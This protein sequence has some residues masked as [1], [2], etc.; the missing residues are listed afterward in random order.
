M[1]ERDQ[2][3]VG[4]VLSMAGVQ[5]TDVAAHHL[6]TM[7]ASVGIRIG[8]ALIYV[9]ERETAELFGR[10][11]D[12]QSRAAAMLPHRLGPRGAREVRGAVDAAVMM[13]VHGLPPVSGRL[14]RPP[15]RPTHLRVQLARVV[16]DIRDQAAFVS[17]RA[18][19]GDACVLG[20][21]VLPAGSDARLRQQRAFGQ[22][23][24]AVPRAARRQGSGT[25]RRA[26]SPTPP[27]AAPRRGPILGQEHTG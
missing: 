11:W 27:P 19:F 5:D 14:V 6:S 23:A 13:N 18:A 24:A 1:Y 21:S 22:A 20:A 26:T 9:H 2:Q 4:V 25:R 10:V 15:G 16:F 17:V 12:R 7:Y 8:S 3:T